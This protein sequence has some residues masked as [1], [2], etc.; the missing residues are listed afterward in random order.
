MIDEFVR[1]DNPAKL[2]I[3]D[4]T[5]IGRGTF[6]NAGGGVSIGADVLIGPDVK[7]WSADHRFDLLDAPIRL[8]GHTFGRVVIGDDVWIGANSI[9]L[10]GVTVGRG[11]VI[12]A[13][14]VVK[15]DVE[16]YAVVAGVPAKIVKLR[17]P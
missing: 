8:Q 17:R 5:F 4:D 7:I 2:S 15:T 6:I 12:A 13:G 14:S 16:D 1:L 9:I 11:A 10:K 3:G